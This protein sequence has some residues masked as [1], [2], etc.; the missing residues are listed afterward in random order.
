[1]ESISVVAMELAFRGG[2]PE[3]HKFTRPVT[4]LMKNC[5]QLLP[6]LLI[7]VYSLLRIMCWLVNNNNDGVATKGCGEYF[8]AIVLRVFC[9]LATLKSESNNYY[10]FV[11]A[12][13]DRIRLKIAVA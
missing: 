5:V 4:H 8:C 9:F 10:C 3:V 1:M 2:E 12:W 11:T 13:G 6:G 7:T